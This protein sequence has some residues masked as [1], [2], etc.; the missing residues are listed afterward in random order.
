VELTTHLHLVPRART[1]GGIPPF[2]NT[3]S[4]RGAQLKHRDNF[5]SVGIALGYRLDDRDSRVRFPA[6]DGNFSFL[7][8]VQTGPGPHP[9]SFP[10]GTGGSFPRA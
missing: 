2:P 5:S 7:H 9:A 1:R 10:M 6:G 8:R 4:W 3:P